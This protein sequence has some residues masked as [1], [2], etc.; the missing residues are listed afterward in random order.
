MLESLQHIDQ[1]LL[2]AINGTHSPFWDQFMWIASEKL[3]WIPMYATLIY[4]FFRNFNWRMAT[5]SIIS[6]ILLITFCDQTCSSLI[7]PCVERMRPSNPDNPLSEFIHIVN[8]YRG[9]RYGFPSSHASNSFGLAFF[10]MFLFKQKKFTIFI[11]GWATLHSYTR[12]YLGVHY[13]GDLLTGACLGFIGAFIVYRLFRY[14]LQQPRFADILHYTEH[15]R[16]K[17]LY[18]KDNIIH[19]KYTLYTGFATILVIALYAGIYM[20][21]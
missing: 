18:P 13:P 7:R 6:V 4:V 14:I 5:F 9:G 2:L 20:L 16:E 8:D 15:D 19:T 3:T 10:L 21:S 1:Q 11:L 12:A 17:I